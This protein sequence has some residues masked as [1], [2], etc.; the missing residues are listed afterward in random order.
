MDFRAFLVYT[1]QIVEAK[2]KFGILGCSRVASKVAPAM[3]GSARAELSMVGSRDPQKA[4]RFAAKYGAKSWGSYEDVVADK[5]L[6]AIYVSLPNTLHEEW[7]IKALAAGKH[8]ICEKPAALTYASAKNMTAAARAN[9]KRLMEGLMFR[10]HP[11]YHRLRELIENGT[12]GELRRFFDCYGMRMRQ[13]GDNMISKDLDGGVLNYMGCYPIAATR[14]IF[15]EEP[16][17]VFCQMEVD[18]ALGVDIRA[19][20]IMNFPKG[21]VAFSSSLLGTSFQSTYSLVG[22]EAY[23]HSD[24]SGYVVRPGKEMNLYI[25]LEKTVKDEAGREDI[26]DTV[27]KE[28]IPAADPDQFHLMLDAFCEEVAGGG[29]KEDYEADLLAQARILEAARRSAKEGRT[30]RIAEI[31]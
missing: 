9:K 29:A 27:Q 16:E 10:Y 3:V 21:K 22:S 23:V 12:L 26:R 14:M 7:A 1:W 17:S 20:M 4:E 25:N 19:D 30:V 8:V 24:R 15:K 11:Q 13:P 2:L 5:E 31:A 18:S 28:T 6:D